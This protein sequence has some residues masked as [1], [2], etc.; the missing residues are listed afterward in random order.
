M[1]TAV[2]ASLAVI[3]TQPPSSAPEASASQ[4]SVVKVS[5]TCSFALLLLCAGAV[6]A[7][8]APRLQPGPPLRGTLAA[9]EMET[10]YDLSVEQGQLIDAQGTVTGFDAGNG[11]ARGIKFDKVIR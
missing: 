7:P 6:P 3:L 11:R 2:L 9:E 8:Q 1:V 10:F 5:V 4:G